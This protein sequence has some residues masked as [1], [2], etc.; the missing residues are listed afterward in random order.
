M[1]FQIAYICAVLLL[2]AQGFVPQPILLKHDDYGNTKKMRVNLAVATPTEE[3]TLTDGEV[4]RHH[5]DVSSHLRIEHPKK[6]G[7]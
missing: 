1:K 6:R 3:P 2:G 4:A 5:D 7:F